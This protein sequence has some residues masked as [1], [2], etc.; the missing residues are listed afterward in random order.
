MR[1]AT[2]GF[3][4]DLMTR[5]G[6]PMNPAAGDRIAELTA[7]AAAMPGQIT[8]RTLPADAERIEREHQAL[9][10]EIGQLRQCQAICQRDGIDWSQYQH[11]PI[12]E[13]RAA[14]LDDMRTTSER[15]PVS[16]HV[17]IQGGG[18]DEDPAVRGLQDAIY[19]RL[20]G[21]RPEGAAAQ[22]TGRSLIEIGRSLLEHRG[23]RGVRSWSRDRIADGMLSRAYHTTSDFPNL[24]TGAGNRVLLDAYQAATSPL[25][26][27]ARPRQVADFRAVTALRLSEAPSLE[28]VSEAGE[29]TSGSRAEAK[30]AYRVFTYARIFSLSR[31]AIVND[32]LSA[33]GD[34]AQAWGQA[35]AN[36]EADELIALFSANAWAGATLDDTLPW[37]DASRGNLAASGAAIDV[38]TLSAARLALRDTKGLDGVTPL[39]LVPAFLLVGSADET[40][41][42]QV[43]ATLAAAQVSAVNPFSGKLTLLV[44]PRLTDGG[45]YVFAAPAQAPV[46][47]VAHLDGQAGPMLE[48]RDGWTTLGTEFRAVLD[49]GCGVVGFRGSYRND[50]AA[51]SP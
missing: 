13:C 28:K 41:G 1:T 21:R 51:G 36:R 45:W 8:D 44:E 11:M 49:V 12:A 26:Q 24:L 38:T 46:L 15:N 30:E 2:H 22:W 19:S 20:T 6:S 47:E 5:D 40:L 50:G 3:G 10:G 17:A 16:S 14:I 7:R 31:Q 37:F 9:L 23:E 32:D 35:A 25:M 43:L 34:M 39:A 48:Q 27:I 29:I 42:E 33:F 4:D 18:T